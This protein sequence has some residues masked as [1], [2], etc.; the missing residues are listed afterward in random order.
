MTDAELTHL[1]TD[2]LRKVVERGQTPAGMHRPICV[3]EI[4]AVLAPKPGE[5][6]PTRRSVAGVVLRSRSAGIFE[7]GLISTK[8]LP[9]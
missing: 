2:E 4:L 1:I 9:N 7:L 5:V 6:G 8:P 3:A